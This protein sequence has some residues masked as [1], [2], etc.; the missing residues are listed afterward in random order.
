MSG[1]Q[2]FIQ[3]KSCFAFEFWACATFLCFY[4]FLKV[5]LQMR[6]LIMSHFNNKINAQ[7]I[8]VI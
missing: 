6:D 8:A 2:W 1:T 4:F 3:S 7:E 5:F